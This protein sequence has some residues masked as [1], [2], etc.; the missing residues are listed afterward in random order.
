MIILESYCILLRRISYYMCK[1]VQKYIFVNTLEVVFHLLIIQRLCVFKCRISSEATRGIPIPNY[2][3]GPPSISQPKNQ[4][5]WC[6]T[7]LMV[8]LLLCVQYTWTKYCVGVRPSL[9]TMRK[10][11]YSGTGRI[12]IKYLSSSPSLHVCFHIRESEKRTEAF[13]IH[14]EPFAMIVQ[15]NVRVS[16]DQFYHKRRRNETRR[17]TVLRVHNQH[18]H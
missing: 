10:Q 7:R 8:N 11:C 18:C 17:N 13:K 1:R 14:L 3:C 9:D 12:W 16:Y 15:I 2:Q 5:K 6:H 4:T